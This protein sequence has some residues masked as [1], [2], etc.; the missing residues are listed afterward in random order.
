MSFRF[1][2]DNRKVAV[3]QLTMALLLTDRV[4]TRLTAHAILITLTLQQSHHH[5]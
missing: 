1:T 3:G 2:V 4:E 5:R